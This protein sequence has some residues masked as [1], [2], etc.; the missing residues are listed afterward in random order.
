MSKSRP[1][2]GEPRTADDQGHH[3]P[4]PAGRQARGAQACPQERPYKHEAATQTQAP[5]EKTRTRPHRNA[6]AL[7]GRGGRTIELEDHN[8]THTHTQFTHCCLW[9]DPPSRRC[10][11]EHPLPPAVG[12]FLSG[13]GWET[14]L[15]TYKHL[16][17][18]VYSFQYKS[19]PQTPPSSPPH[20]LSPSPPNRD[21]ICVPAKEGPHSPTPPPSPKK[22]TKHI[23]PLQTGRVPLIKQGHTPPFHR[24]PHP[25]NLHPLHFKG[26]TQTAP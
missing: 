6:G 5:M 10:R 14:A 17:S 22:K 13:M 23:Q 3:T 2:H 18:P 4:N 25:T 8:V 20:K 7:C 19:F 21:P 24:H 16:V 9:D 11:Q 15:F 26:W 1:F 12:F